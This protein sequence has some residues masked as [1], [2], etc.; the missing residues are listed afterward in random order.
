MLEPWGQDTMPNGQG[1]AVGDETHRDKAL[2][3][4]TVMKYSVGN[5]C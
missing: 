5:S 4:R 1:F 2:D 3:G